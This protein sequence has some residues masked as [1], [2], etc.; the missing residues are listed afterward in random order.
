M[1][2]KVA[3]GV[4]VVLGHVAPTPRLSE[5]AA[6]ALEGKAVTEETATA[7]GEAACEG[8]RPLSQNEYKVQ[9]LKVAV[10]RAV[11]LAAGAKPYWEG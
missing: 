6:K 1:D 4:R 5:S 10:K 2:G 8:A 7:A 11:L 3:R 9:Q